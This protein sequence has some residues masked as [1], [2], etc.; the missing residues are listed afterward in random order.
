VGLWG[1]GIIRGVFVGET[2]RIGGEAAPAGEGS[3][4]CDLVGRVIGG[5]HETA[6]C[7]L[8]VQVCGAGCGVEEHAGPGVGSPI[9][10]RD[11]LGLSCCVSVGR[12]NGVRQRKSGKSPGAR[13]M[14][15][16]LLKGMR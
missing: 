9:L 8:G 2:G 7:Y 12:G 3:H 10:G 5:Q 16:F 6:R 11:A 4:R 14:W 1:V 15:V 13:E